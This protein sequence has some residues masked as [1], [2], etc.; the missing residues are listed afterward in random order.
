M[1]STWD[2]D[3]RGRMSAIQVTTVH[4]VSERFGQT[5]ISATSVT[6]GAPGQ[7]VKVEDVTDGSQAVLETLTVRVRP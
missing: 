5:Q 6:V 7:T 1:V 2:I 4:P 3:Q